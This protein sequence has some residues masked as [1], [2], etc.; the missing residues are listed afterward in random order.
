M[1]WLCFVSITGD[2]AAKQPNLSKFREELGKLRH[3][4]DGWILERPTTW[5][6]FRSSFLPGVLRVATKMTWKWR[7]IRTPRAY[8]EL[9]NRK[10]PSLTGKWGLIRLGSLTDPDNEM[11]IL[12]WNDI[13]HFRLF[14]RLGRKWSPEKQFHGLIELLS[15]GLEGLK[16]MPGSLSQPDSSWWRS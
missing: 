2:R 8:S 14:S 3:D 12:Y 16:M 11:A 4:D 1:E 15:K 7:D 5:L 6:Q 13:R 10:R 9:E